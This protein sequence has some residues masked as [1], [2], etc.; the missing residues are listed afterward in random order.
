MFMIFGLVCYFIVYCVVILST[1][2][3]DTFETSIVYCVVILSTDTVDTFET[4]VT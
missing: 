1:D 4:S 3:V 2:T